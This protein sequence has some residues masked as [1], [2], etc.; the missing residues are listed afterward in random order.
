MLGTP[1][2]SKEDSLFSDGKTNL[3]W[4]V[5]LLLKSEQLCVWMMRHFHT[6]ST[7]TSEKTSL[8]LKPEIEIIKSIYIAKST[9]RSILHTISQTAQTFWCKRKYLYFKNK[10]KFKDITFDEKKLT[11][12]NENLTRTRICMG[13]K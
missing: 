9:H 1:R 12:K 13:E 3:V 11:F 6:L 7:R 10:C 4:H 5:C 8:F 2:E